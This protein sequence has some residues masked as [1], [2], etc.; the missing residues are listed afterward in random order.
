[1]ILEVKMSPNDG[2]PEENNKKRKKFQWLRFG[3]YAAYGITDPIDPANIRADPSIF[4][5]L[6]EIFGVKEKTKEEPEENW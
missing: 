1:M 6:F 2:N 4:D 5:K 3:S